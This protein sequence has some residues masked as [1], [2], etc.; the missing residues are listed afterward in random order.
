M[1]F[2]DIRVSKDG[3]QTF[4]DWRKIPAGELGDFMQP[5]V[6]RRWGSARH[7]VFQTRVTD[8][9]RADVVAASIQ[10]EA[11]GQ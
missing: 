7:F 3:G 6:A 2:L 5:I 4:S 1:N 11:A 9:Y 8:D 10:L